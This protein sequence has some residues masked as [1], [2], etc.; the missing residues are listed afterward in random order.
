MLYADGQK[1][2]NLWTNCLGQ[3]FPSLPSGTLT[4]TIPKWPFRNQQIRVDVYTHVGTEAQDWIEEGLVFDSHDGD[5]YGTGVI[6]NPDQG[7]MFL[8]HSW[9]SDAV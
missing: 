8:D 7:I 6:T 4:C 5:F 2:A 9:T 1:L 3:S